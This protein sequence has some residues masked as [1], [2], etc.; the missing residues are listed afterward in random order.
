MVRTGALLTVLALCVVLGPVELAGRGPSARSV[1]D[2]TVV[3]AQA[4]ESADGEAR[5]MAFAEVE[6]RMAAPMWRSPRVR[7]NSIRVGKLRPT[8]P[9]RRWTSHMMMC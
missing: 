5:W 1:H 2:A 9:R 6:E 8:P 3:D 4:A 7:T